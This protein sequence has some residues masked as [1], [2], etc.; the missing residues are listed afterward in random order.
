MPI[1]AN[2]TFFPQW[3]AQ[4]FPTVP[5]RPPLITALNRFREDGSKVLHFL[6]IHINTIIGLR[7]C[8]A[9]AKPE[10]LQRQGRLADCVKIEQIK[11]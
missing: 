4:P 9:F 6:Y 3:E 8:Q 1:T 2:R 7:G 10:S 5:F 11:N